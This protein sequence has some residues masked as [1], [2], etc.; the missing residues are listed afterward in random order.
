MGPCDDRGG[1]RAHHANAAARIAAVHDEAATAE[2]T[3]WRQ[4]IALYEVLLSLDEN[5]VI[6]LNHAVAVSIVD[7]PQAGLAL[8]D[9]LRLDPRVGTD[10]RVHAVRGH[11]LE[12]EGDPEAAADAF[13]AARSRTTHVAQQRYLNQQITRLENIKRSDQRE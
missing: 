8:L 9:R 7:G 6:A 11:L 3:D 12:R 13:R 4:I 10:R 5:P 2:A 1:H